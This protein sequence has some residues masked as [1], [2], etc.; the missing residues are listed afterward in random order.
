MA[1]V[2]AV[3]VVASAA[4]FNSEGLGGLPAIAGIIAVAGAMSPLV[5][6]MQWFQAKIFAKLPGE[7]FVVERRLP[8]VGIA[9]VVAAFYVFIMGPGLMFGG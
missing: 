2:T 8:I 5:W 9:I 4:S 6:M 7:P 3:V 1:Y